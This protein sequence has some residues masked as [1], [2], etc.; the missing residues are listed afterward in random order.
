MDTESI[1][2][3]P[4]ILLAFDFLNR[5]FGGVKEGDCYWAYRHQIHLCYV[6]EVG[7]LDNHGDKVENFP[8]EIKITSCV[9]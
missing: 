3:F 6:G 5:L 4:E 2:T 8:M 9:G 7:Q 1:E